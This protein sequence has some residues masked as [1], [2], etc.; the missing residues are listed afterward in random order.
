MNLQITLIIAT[1]I[2]ALLIFFVQYH[3]LFRGG[4]VKKKYFLL[5]TFSIFLVLIGHLLE[6]TGRNTSGAFSGVRLLY[7]GSAFV[8]SCLLFFVADYCDI[9]IPNLIRALIIAAA[10]A[11]AAIAWTTN[12]TGLL[13]A[14]MEYDAGH[15]YYLLYTPG[16]LS[17]LSRVFPMLHAAAAAVMLVYR[18]RR[19]GRRGRAALIVMLVATILPSICETA[20]YVLSLV[21]YTRV[22]IY[23][24]PYVLAAIVT[25]I[26]YGIMRYDIDVDAVAAIVA[27]DTIS[28]PFI[29]LDSELCVLSSNNAAR[30][31]FP[32]LRDLP[33]DAPVNTRREWPEALPR[34]TFTNENISVEFTL[35]EDDRRFSASVNPTAVRRRSELSLWSILIR[36]VTDSA[37]FIKRLEAAA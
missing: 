37:N 2:A 29:L 1:L 15:T 32:W 18:I 35:R 30:T 22:N 10:A 11:Y 25:F 33:R 4:V 21:G 3:I 12:I 16:P 17:L 19:S 13:Y 24:T 26:Y 6:L 5:L 27:M 9:K 20:F 7:L 36:D 28:E 34:S 23:I 14:S 31:L 8:S